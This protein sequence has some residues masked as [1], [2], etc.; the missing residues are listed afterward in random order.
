[1]NLLAKLLLPSVTLWLTGAQAASFKDC[2]ACPEMESLPAGEFQ[3]GALM[4]PNAVPI[5][6][7][8]LRAFAIGKYE[9]TQGEWKAVMGSN[10]SKSTACGDACPVENVN[11]QEAREF[12]KRLSATTGSTYRLPTEAEWEYACRAGEQHDFCGGS[13]PNTVAWVGDQYGGIH[14]VGQKQPNAWGLYDMSGNVW[15]WTQDCSHA[16]YKGAPTDGS[17]WEAQ[18][19]T[20]ECNSRILRGGSWLSGP[21]YSR[22]TLRFGFTPRFHAGDFGFR[23][24]R[25]LK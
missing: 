2:A 9:V 21:Q 20:G 24:V 17:A 19:A 22:A 8:T 7:V 6:A 1:M 11:W 16:D 10:P 3:M 12:A 4:P 23:V 13:D 15:E 14:P 25:E 5:H 18:A